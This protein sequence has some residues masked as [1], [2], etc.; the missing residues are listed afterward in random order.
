MIYE[1]DTNV[2]QVLRQVRLMNRFFEAIDVEPYR[3]H[4]AALH[5]TYMELLEPEI[6]QH[7]LELAQAVIEWEES[8]REGERQ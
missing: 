4:H 8:Q 5:C 2:A 6:A 3:V 7:A 1:N